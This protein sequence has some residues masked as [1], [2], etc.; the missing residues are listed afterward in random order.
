M[1]SQ[2]I[3]LKELFELAT[4]LGLSVYFNGDKEEAEFSGCIIGTED[5]LIDIINGNEDLENYDRVIGVETD[6]KKVGLH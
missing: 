4:E 2:E 3:A 5:F 1:K 6:K